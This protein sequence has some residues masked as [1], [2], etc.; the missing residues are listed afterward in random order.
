MFKTWPLLFSASMHWPLPPPPML[1]TGRFSDQSVSCFVS[2]QNSRK[3]FEFLKIKVHRN[4]NQVF[5]WPFWYFGV[6]FHN[7]FF[8]YFHGNVSLMSNTKLYNMHFPTPV[9]VLIVTNSLDIFVCVFYVY[10]YVCVLSPW[11]ICFLFVFFI[12][13]PP[14]SPAVNPAGD[15]LLGSHIRFSWLSADFIQASQA[16]N[17]RR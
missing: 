9:L 10:V 1:T 4:V 13:V 12:F 16:E 8:L 5:K 14:P 2:V 15:P 7:I 11:D 17:I 3:P 6:S